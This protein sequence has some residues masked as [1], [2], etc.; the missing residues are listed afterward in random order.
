MVGNDI[1]ND[2]RRTNRSTS[3]A[4]RNREMLKNIRDSFKNSQMHFVADTNTSA[5][6]HVGV[7]VEADT[8]LNMYDDDL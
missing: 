2:R 3:R 8:E 6:G 5:G 7:I 1:G 4:K